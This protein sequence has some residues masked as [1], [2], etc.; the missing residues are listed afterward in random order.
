MIWLGCFLLY[1]IRIAYSF[2]GNTFEVFFFLTQ[3]N[4]GYRLAKCC[5]YY[6]E[7]FYSECF[8]DFYH[9]RML[10]FV[11]PPFLLLSRLQCDFCPCLIMCCITFVYIH[12]LNCPFLFWINPTWTWWMFFLTFSWIQF[13]LS[14]YFIYIRLKNSTG[15]IFFYH[16]KTSY[17][18]SGL[19][20]N[21]SIWNSKSCFVVSLVAYFAPLNLC[22]SL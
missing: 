2:S 15:I 12:V 5:L 4:I 1:W 10:D 16:G 9:E 6:V 20:K 19:Y 22:W 3:Y 13:I 21:K 14:C 18:F 11:N 7:I 8:Q 17:L